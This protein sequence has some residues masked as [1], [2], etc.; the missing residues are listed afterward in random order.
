[1]PSLRPASLRYLDGW[2]IGGPGQRRARLQSLKARPMMARAAPAP[3]PPAASADGVFEEITVTDSAPAAEATSAVSMAASAAEPPETDGSDRSDGGEAQPVR[4]NFAETAFWFP[5]LRLDTDGAARLEFTVPDSVTEWKVWAHALT[6]DLRGGSVTKTTRSVKDLLIRPYLPRFLRAGDRAELRLVLSNAG[7]R[8]LAG[9]ADVS[10]DDPE[11]GEDLLELFGLTPDRAKELA[12]AVEPGQTATLTVPLRAPASPRAISVTAAAR[13]DELSDG[14]RRPLPILPSRLHLAQSRFA[15]VQGPGQR[16]LRFA[17]LAAA[18]D[19][20]LESESLV[21]TLDGQLLTT[22]LRALPYLVE[23]PYRCTE[24]TLNRYLSTGILS[25]LYG[26][27]PGVAALGRRLAEE[28]STLLEPWRE[29]DPNRRLLLEE[30]PWL[31]HSRGA[32]E[33]E[34][35]LKVLDPEVAEEVR[36]TALAELRKIQTSDGG[37]PW[38]PGGPPSPY[39]TLYTLQGFARGLEFGL[40]VPKDMAVAGWRYL[41]RH[42]RDE[43]GPKVEASPECC[44]PR[45]TFYAWLLWAFPDA[46]WTGDVFT[47]DDRRLILERAAAQWKKLSPRLKGYLALALVRAGEAERA[48]LVWGSVMDSATTDADLGTYWAPE[49]QAWLWY[50][51]TVESHAF[52]L[53]VLM[54]LD[55]EDPRRRGLVQ[56]LLL[57]KKLG[58]WKSTRATAEAVYAL[59]AFMEAEGTLGAGQKARLRFGPVDERYAF[60]PEDDGRRQRVVDGPEVSS[61]MA[62]I[63]VS[64]ET[65]GLLF[66]SATWHFATDQLPAEARGDFFHVER[67]FFRRE[68]DGERW[69]LVPLTDGD[70]IAVGDSV[71]VQLQIRAKHAAE[72]VQ[73]RDPRGAGFEPEDTTSG[74]AWDSGLGHYREIRDSAVNYFFEWLPAGEYAFRYRL[75]AATAGTFRVGPAQLQSIYAPEFVA[76]SSGREVAIE[77]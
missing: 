59:A 51:D 2:P 16:T 48:A 36:S 77:E 35:L 66:A 9:V 3:A 42:W 30:T 18:D 64:N 54:A 4:S 60:A 53:R 61:E 74:F 56:W 76:Y 10:I 71:E 29:D 5:H 27:H 47:E 73:L 8:P 32:G 67:A 69:R 6:R 23:Y 22:A 34:G 14:E 37:F 11:T 45:L 39:M 1:L 21:I 28:R 33:P 46:S 25:R 7:D 40:D 31:S 75:R 55:P 52:A 13:A 58:H 49:D 12:F 17:D 62:E 26:E 70:P 43:L 24:Q 44:A 15:A 57:D 38:W 65:P 72:Y 41:E 20:S 63:E 50:N 68:L 19:P